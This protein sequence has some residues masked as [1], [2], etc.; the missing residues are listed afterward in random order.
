MRIACVIEYVLIKD[1]VL[2][3]MIISSIRASKPVKPNKRKSNEPPGP[4]DSTESG[5][6]SGDPIT[7]SLWQLAGF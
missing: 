2:M 7:E 6:P 4:R 1:A 5:E 3:I